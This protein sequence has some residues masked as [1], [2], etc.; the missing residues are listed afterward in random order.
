[1]KVNLDILIINHLIIN[2]NERKLLVDRQTIRQPTTSKQYTLF[3]SKWSVITHMKVILKT[4]LV[5][6]YFGL[7]VF[8]FHGK[9][10]YVS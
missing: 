1:M 6:A 7:N 9:R 4:V 3:S 5:E 10:N 2:Q 8:Y